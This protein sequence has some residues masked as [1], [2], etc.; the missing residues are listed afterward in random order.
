MF[1]DA[2]HSRRKSDEQMTNFNCERIPDARE[3]PRDA[4]PAGGQ[5][6]LGR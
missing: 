3:T 2:P 5:T 6:T 1:H 4:A